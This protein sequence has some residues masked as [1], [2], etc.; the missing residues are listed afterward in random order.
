MSP[1]QQLISDYLSRLSAAARG[2][3]S[4]DDRRALVNRTHD[5]IER[6]TD[7]GRPPTAIEVARLLSGLGD[8]VRLVGQ[9]RQRLAALRGEDLKPVSRGRLTRMLH[10]DPGRVRGAS[11][12][13]PVQEG[14]RTDLQLTLLDTGAPAAANGAGSNGTGGGHKSAAPAVREAAETA[15]L[16]PAPP[17]DVAPAD[18]AATREVVA[19]GDVTDISVTVPA[20]T[21]PATTVP[22]KTVPAETVP[23]EA[24][25]VTWSVAAPAIAIRGRAAAVVVRLATWAGRNKVEATAVVLL[26]V[27]GAIFPP[28]WLVGA[29]V[30]MAS[31]LWD[32]RDKWLGLGVPVLLT[33]IGIAVGI[34]A[35]GSGGT[36]GMHIHLGWVFADVISRLTALLGAGYLTWRSTRGR[37]PPAPPPWSKPR[38]LA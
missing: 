23:M 18:V 32:L 25:S 20:R 31:R 26:G 3:L 7:L 30:T 2:Q 19:N 4:P 21:V 13:W 28:V 1:A 24:E 17:A 14:S 5:F 12:H 22:A 35:V 16:A 34:A 9:E 33:V 15:A 11:W 8:P 29:V 38:K 36:I 37:R 27:G 6:K 10:G